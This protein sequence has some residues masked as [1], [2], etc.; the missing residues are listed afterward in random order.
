MF[1]VKRSKNNPI[2]TPVKDHPFES[3]AT[4]NGNPVQVGGNIYLLY[5]AQSLPETFENNH[6]SL[7]VIGKAI[8]SNG[9]DFKKREQFI[10]PEVEYDKM[11]K[12][13][14]MDITFVITTP[15]KEQSKRLLELFGFP[16]RK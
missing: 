15:K 5:R 6:F 13:Q 14:G 2:L 3:F 1:V 7:S 16:F 9:I 12:I 8:S 4:F 10:F 11:R